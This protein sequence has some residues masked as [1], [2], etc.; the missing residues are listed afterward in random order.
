MV[1]IIK[2]GCWNSTWHAHKTDLL[3]HKLHCI[4]IGRQEHW[5]IFS[6][7]NIL[8]VYNQNTLALFLVFDKIFEWNCRIVK[9]KWLVNLKEYLFTQNTILGHLFI[10]LWKT[11]HLTRAVLVRSRDRLFSVNT[12][13][14]CLCVLEQ[15]KITP[16]LGP[17]GRN[18]SS[19]PTLHLTFCCVR[20]WLST[21][22]SSSP[23]YWFCV[24]MLGWYL[25]WVSKISL[26]HTKI[27][28]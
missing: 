4:Q 19:W 22:C 13:V 24:H 9:Y 12:A 20:S 18:W 23:S 7:S 10:Q 17:I 25:L 11:V 3:N 1:Q 16:A 27:S 5:Q 6:F 2:S 15:P 14:C 21:I 26:C 28:N 8:Y